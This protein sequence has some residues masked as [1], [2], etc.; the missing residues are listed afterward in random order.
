MSNLR[1][2]KIGKFS[3]NVRLMYQ[4]LNLPEIK[5]EVLIFLSDCERFSY[6]PNIKSGKVIVGYFDLHG[7]DDI[8]ITDGHVIYDCL[9]S[10]SEGIQ[11]EEYNRPS[12]PDKQVKVCKNFI[13]K[14]YNMGTGSK[15]NEVSC[16]ECSDGSCVNCKMYLS[17]SSKC[18]NSKIW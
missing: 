6:L 1:W 10:I 15:C 2:N 9:S 13:C 14:K 18:K 12:Q 4:D 17:Q 3:P 11:W 7:E 5:Q 8:C 16:K